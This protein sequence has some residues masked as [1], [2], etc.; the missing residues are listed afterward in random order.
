MEYYA[1]VGKNATHLY[2]LDMKGAPGQIVM[3]E[4]KQG[5]KTVY[6]MYILCKERGEGEIMN[7]YNGTCLY[8]Q[9]ETPQVFTSKG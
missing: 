1:A 3:R 4:K 8:M 7:L 5:T 2:V 9:R 6:K